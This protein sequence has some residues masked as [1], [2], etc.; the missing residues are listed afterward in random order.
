MENLN[1]G[2]TKKIKSA[3]KEML[4]QNGFRTD[5][6]EIADA[7]TLELV[8]DWNG[9]QKIVVLAAAFIDKVRLIDNLGINT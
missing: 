8:G 3:A 9:N 5:Y 4:L 1:P 7:D 6:I 2:N